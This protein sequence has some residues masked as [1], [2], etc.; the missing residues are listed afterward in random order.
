MTETQTNSPFPYVRDL[1]ETITAVLDFIRGHFSKLLQVFLIMVAPLSL[2]TGSVATFFTDSITNI[3]IELNQSGDM[4]NFSDMM[5]LIFIIYAISLLTTSMNITVSTEYCISIHKNGSENFSLGSFCK[6]C[7]KRYPSNIIT[8]LVS[9]LMVIVGCVFC[10]LP[11]IYIAIPLAQ[12]FAVRANER[13]SL[14][15]SIGRCFTIIKG[16]WWSTFGLSLVV[17]VTI[18]ILMMGLY[19]PLALFGIVKNTFS[20]SVEP[21]TISSNMSIISILIT[22][23]V[24]IVNQFFVSSIYIT[25]VFRYFSLAEQN[26]GVSMYSQID[27]IGTSHDSNLPEETY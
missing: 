19:V 10:L 24:G 26:D 8:T 22:V 17:G 14:T 2:V 7:F 6:H 15:D 18:F 16:S 21:S 25:H 3:S 9:A 11:G 5:V 20:T 12:I 23:L 4:S 1:G 27:K 13:S